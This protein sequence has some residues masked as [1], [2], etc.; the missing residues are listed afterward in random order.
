MTDDDHTASLVELEAAIAD[1]TDR[2]EELEATLKDAE[3]R[4]GHSHDRVDKL[5]ADLLNIDRRM[6]ELERSTEQL[7]DRLT[8]IEDNRQGDRTRW[9]QS[10]A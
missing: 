7:W 5:A 2:I 3:S 6:E 8:A 9:R 10:D 4:L 1:R